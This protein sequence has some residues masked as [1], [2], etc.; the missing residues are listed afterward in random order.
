MKIYD[1]LSFFRA[2]IGYT[3]LALFFLTLLLCALEIAPGL[4]KFFLSLWPAELALIVVYTALSLYEDY[5]NN[6]VFSL[7]R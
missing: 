6:R 5:R 7:Y 3:S 2:A 4:T 1:S